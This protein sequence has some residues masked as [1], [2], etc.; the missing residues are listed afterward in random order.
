MG[1]SRAFAECLEKDFEH[2]S[3]HIRQEETDGMLLDNSMEGEVLSKDEQ[4]EVIESDPDE[5]EEYEDAY[6]SESDEYF[7]GETAI[8]QDLVDAVYGQNEVSYLSVGIFI[9]RITSLFLPFPLADCKWCC[10]TT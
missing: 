5:G 8:S 1:F 7:E 4:D 6:Q 10:T 3:E 9:V 2:I